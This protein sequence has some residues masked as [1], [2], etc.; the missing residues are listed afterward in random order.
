MPLAE[1]ILV[2]A[3][4]SAACM[5]MAAR[6]G[7]GGRTRALLLGDVIDQFGSYNSFT[8]IGYDPAI[9][10]TLIPSVPQF[11]GGYDNAQRNLRVYMPRTY[12]IL[13]ERY[14]VLVFSDADRLVFTPEWIQWLS[15]SVTDD[16]LGMLWLG[17]ITAPINMAG[18]EDTTV[19]EVL[20]ASQPAGEL[21]I[22][23]SFLMRVLE[24]NEPLMQALPWEEAPSLMN[25]NAQVPKDGSEY[26]AKLVST[27]REYPLMT[28]WEVGEGEVLSFASK[29]PMGVRIWAK[30]WPLFPPAMIYMTY[31]VSDKR[32]PDDPFLFLSIIN[33]FIEFGETTSL[34][35][36]ILEWV[37]TFGGNTRKLRERIGAL[38]GV[39][40]QAEEA[41]LGGN[42]NDAY[43]IL[44]EAKTEQ[45]ALRVAASRAK[46]EALFWVYVTE[47]LALT[48]T[49]LVS[50]YALWA[51][52]VRRRLY[53]EVGVS[54]LEPRID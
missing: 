45:A 44:A 50:S 8:V 18:W 35:E 5:G 29:F 15:S 9:E 48:G 10:V 38:N 7:Q 34:V 16:G 37:E 28:Y 49:F 11:V 1:T 2:L 42:F 6:A 13:V 24:G 20:P 23:A 43:D 3:M 41:Y 21:T 27:S 51:L 33:D 17:S 52:M 32:L 12:E 36:S 30:D 40:L 53:R 4:L 14:E 54:R 22:I 47:W 46:D 19:A 31:R 25:V 26:W 39:E